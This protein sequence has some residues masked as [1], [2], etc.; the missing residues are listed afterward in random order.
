MSD[1]V[2]SVCVWPWKMDAW[3]KDLAAYIKSLD[4]NH[5]VIDGRQLRNRDISPA[6][7]QDPH[8]DIITDHFYPNLPFSFSDRLQHMATFTQGKKPFMV[9][10]FGLVMP[11]TLETLL[12]TMLA[13]KGVC[14]GLMWS[15]RSHSRTGGFYWHYEYDNYWAYHY[16]GFDSNEIGGERAVLKMMTKYAYAIQ[17][18]DIP[19]EQPPTQPS[20]IPTSTSDQ[21]AWRGSVGAETYVLQ[22]SSVTTTDP[23]TDGDKQQEQVTWATVATGLLD[24]SRPFVPYADTSAEPGVTYYYRIVA[25]N[26]AGQSMPSEAVQLHSSSSNNTV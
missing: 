20:I 3:V 26:S 9:G 12:V 13:T 16:P 18:K 1:L 4:P 14:G 7:L 8:V 6:M 15:L 10:E 19:P 24:S 5:L 21:I 22:R 11:E 17:D 23:T 25:I 2:L